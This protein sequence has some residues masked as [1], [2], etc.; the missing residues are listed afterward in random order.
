LPA[1]N[2]RIT[3]AATMTM[4]H[5]TLTWLSNATR[6]IPAMFIAS[7]ISMRMPIVTSCPL[8]MPGMSSVVLKTPPVSLSTI[9]ALMN[10]AAA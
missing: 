1:R 5:Q 10:P 8:R 6:L 9:V 3:T 2:T 7:W 4:C